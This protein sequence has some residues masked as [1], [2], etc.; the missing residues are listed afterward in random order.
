MTVKNRLLLVIAAA[1]VAVCI[2]AFLRRETPVASPDREANR[3]EE[4][5]P[6]LPSQRVSVLI[7]RLQSPADA[8]W[9]EAQ[10]CLAALGVK[11]LDGLD[12]MVI[13]GD[14]EAKDR[15]KGILAIAMLRTVGWEDVKRRAHLRA[16]VTDEVIEGFRIAEA[17]ANRTVLDIGEAPMLRPGF[18]HQPTEVQKTLAAF[19]EL[20]GFGVPAALHLCADENPVA[21][22]YGI[23]LLER[24]DATIAKDHV[25]GMEE[26]FEKL[27]VRGSD[28]GGGSCVARRAESFLAN[29]SRTDSTAMRIETYI[30]NFLVLNKSPDRYSDLIN[31][32]R[33]IS[34]ARYRKEHPNVRD[35]DQRWKSYNAKTWDGWWH[36]ARPAWNEWW[37]LHGTGKKPVEREVWLNWVNLQTKGFT[38]Q[39]RQNADGTSLLR[40]LE[41][42]GARCE[43]YHDGAL[44]EQGLVPL[45]TKKVPKNSMKI[46]V[47]Y[48]NGGIWEH[49]FASN[50]GSTFT[51]RIFLAN[52]H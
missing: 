19:S 5:D 41:P 11:A 6:T 50:A 16:L 18:K 51:V 24:I 14:P 43:I 8:R 3:A 17:L 15:A 20:R 44:V 10:V 29:R 4:T 25:S 9:R 33:Q 2:A 7:D 34:L 27:S 48:A 12:A 30:T 37:E 39:R 28:W 1:L 52:P 46:V 13:E 32:I 26:D 38:L 49:T 40:V 31:G 23:L 21:R 47:R 36:D 42:K 35:S 22:A 45:E